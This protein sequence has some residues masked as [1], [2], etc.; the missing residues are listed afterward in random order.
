MTDSEKL[1]NKAKTNEKA[2][3]TT[4]HEHFEFVFNAVI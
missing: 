3:C 4:V 2:E 1:K